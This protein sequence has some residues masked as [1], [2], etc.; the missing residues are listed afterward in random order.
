[1]LIGHFTFPEPKSALNIL[2]PI[3][4]TI[5]IN[6]FL[7]FLVF[8]IF[9]PNICPKQADFVLNPFLKE[10]AVNKCVARVDSD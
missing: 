9:I 4:K 10:E 1:M 5:K 2:C 3:F 6:A 8:F 7:W